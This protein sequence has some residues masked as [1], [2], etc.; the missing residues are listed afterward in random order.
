MYTALGARRMT[1]QSISQ[2][3]HSI[4]ADQATATFLRLR[5]KTF[6]NKDYFKC[7]V[8]PLMNIKLHGRAL[9]VGCGFGG[10]SFVLAELRPDIHVI[11]V[12]LEARAVASAAIT[13]A[14]R[15]QTNVGAGNDSR[16]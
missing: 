3:R 13:A 7:I 16:I 1:I 2:S 14:Q 9:D 10:L 12:D 6:Y 5:V 4:W 11:G 15:R 8:L